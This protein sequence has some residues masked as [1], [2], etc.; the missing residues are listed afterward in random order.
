MGVRLRIR[1]ALHFLTHKIIEYRPVFPRQAASTAA[2]ST[3]PTMRSAMSHIVRCLNGAR[4]TEVRI[5]KSTTISLIIAEMQVWT[6]HSKKYAQFAKSRPQYLA[7]N[8][9]LQ[10]LDSNRWKRKRERGKINRNFPF[11]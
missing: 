6:A 11:E 3:L 1:S 2:R 9:K 10:W 8:T 7:I 4:C 5:A